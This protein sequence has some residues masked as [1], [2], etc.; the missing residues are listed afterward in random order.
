MIGPLGKLFNNIEVRALTVDLLHHGIVAIHFEV[1]YESTFHA[2]L[3]HIERLKEALNVVLDP[4]WHS[5][6]AKTD[7]GEVKESAVSLDA[8]WLREIVSKS[9]LRREFVSVHVKVI[10]LLSF[11]LFHFSES[12]VNFLHFREA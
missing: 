6:E 12:E 1:T 9:W 8:I 3:L 2:D 5:D 7:T 4:A 10:N 11:F